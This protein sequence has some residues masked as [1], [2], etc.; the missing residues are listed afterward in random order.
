MT[1]TVLSDQLAMDITVPEVDD[2]T[3]LQRCYD[4]ALGAVN[5]EDI[6]CEKTIQ[7]C[8]RFLEDLQKSKS[9]DYPWEFDE[10][11]AGRPGRFIE[12]FLSPTKGDYDSMHLMDWQCFC[13]C[14]L[15]GW[16]DKKTRL[17]R[18]R[19]GLI[20]VG[21][22]NGK[23]TLL[24]GNATYA[25]CKDGER[26]ADIYL[27]ANSKEQAGIVFGEC[28]AQIDNSPALAKRFRTLRDGVYY[29]RM[30]ATIRHRSSDSKRLDG[31]NPHM[32]IFDEIHEYKTFDLINIIKRKVVKRTQPLIIYITTMGKVLD[33]P[34]AYYYDLF[35]DAIYGKLAPEVGDRM[36][37]FIAEMDPKD[38]INDS[39]LW[40]KANP[41]L[42][43]TLKLKDLEETWA[44]VQNV[45]AERADFI[46]KQLNIMVNADDMAFV[47]PEVIKRNDKVIDESTLLGRRCYGGFDLSERE[48]FTAAAL[49]FPL[50]DGSTFVKLHSWVP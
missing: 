13:E 14:Q 33:G 11:L 45:P 6:R 10:D 50:E 29:D 7:A 18:Y 40:I 17:R 22:G 27:L 43:V 41:S 35:T 20:L 26:G 47:G 30:E 32:A 2:R 28:K 9:P 38:D 16:V 19:E 42:G 3:V 24:A 39:S 36:F 25:A 49:E 21:T 31:L 12:S 5:G 8:R 4:Y 23:S 34:L 1:L 48:D 37:G 44:R 46:C 15:Y